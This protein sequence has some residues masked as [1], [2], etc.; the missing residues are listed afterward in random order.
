MK[1]LFISTLLCL[2]ALSFLAHAQQ[3]ICGDVNG[4]GVINISD[5]N[6]IIDMILT[7]SQTSPEADV[8]YDNQVTIADVNLVINAIL[9][10][11]LPDP[12]GTE[13]FN[14][15]GVKFKM[16]TVEGGTFTMGA[17]KEQLRYAT[18]WE[19]PTHKVILSDFALG[20]TEV[21]QELWLAVV[22]GP[23][24]SYFSSRLNGCAD[25]FQRPVEVVSWDDCQRFIAA[26]NQLTG[27]QFH[28]PTEAQWEYAARGG[29]N[30]KKY[31]YSG[32]NSI[33][34]VAWFDQNYGGTTHA[35]AM[36]QPNELGLYDMSG[37]VWEWCQD[38]MDYYTSETQADPTGPESP[39]SH[40]FN[41]T[42]VRGG[43]WH[44]D[45]TNCRVAYRYYYQNLK[46]NIIG[47]RLAL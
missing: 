42:V 8:N 43:S 36:K 16:I 10:G 47:F 5:V 17:T 4:D 26:L 39:S 18:S 15:N 23:N 35:V 25:D 45:S 38:W 1:K 13:T 30:S 44:S 7:G 22:G 14:V 3:T 28:L 21:T 41:A 20:Q 46:T 31:L 33:A 6:S 9:G 32:S 37:N 27:R 29:K 34:D 40:W 12:P 19:K 24:P 11:V 2:M